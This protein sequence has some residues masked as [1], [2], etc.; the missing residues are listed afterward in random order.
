M[1]ADATDMAVIRRKATH[2]VSLAKRSVITKMMR[3]PF[4]E[5]VMGP[6]MSTDSSVRDSVAGNSVKG[7]VC[8]R[9]ARRFWAQIGHLVAV[10]WMSVTI[11]GQSYA[12]RIVQYIRFIPG[13]AATVALCSSVNTRSRNDFGITNWLP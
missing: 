9:K 2:L 7:V 12:F 5:A 13:W 4:L 8:R 10:V 1:M 6:K 11:E 3:V